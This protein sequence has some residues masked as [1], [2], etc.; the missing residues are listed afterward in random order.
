MKKRGNGLGIAGFV[1]SLISLIFIIL[2][3]FI[4]IILAIVSLILC[5][6]QLR[7]EKNGLAIAGLI[8]SIV[9]IIVNTLVL[10]AVMIVWEIV[11]ESIR[12]TP[13]VMNEKI[14]EHINNSY[15]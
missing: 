7:K 8:L 2:L 5:I 14:A 12:K 4:G 15:N 11:Q 13:Q 3:P 9:S 6:I 10:I 1:I